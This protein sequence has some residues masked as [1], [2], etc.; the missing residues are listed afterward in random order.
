MGLTMAQVCETRGLRLGLETL[1][2]S[3]FGPIPPEIATAIATADRDTL[4]SWITAA[5]TAQT[6]ADVG[7]AA[8]NQVAAAATRHSPL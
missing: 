2:T 3:R 7:I 1:L 5:A 6:L 4:Q 8:P